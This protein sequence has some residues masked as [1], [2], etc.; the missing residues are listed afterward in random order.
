MADFQ[1]EVLLS[2]PQHSKRFKSYSD[3]LE[4]ILDLY[5]QT[6]YAWSLKSMCLN[7]AP[8]IYNHCPLP[9]GN[10]GNNDFHITEKLLFKYILKILQL[11]KEIF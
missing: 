3:F 7:Y 9:T 1:V 2:L 10:R 8:V 5:F 11:K 4:L 6:S